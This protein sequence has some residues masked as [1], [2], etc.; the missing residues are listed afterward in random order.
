MRDLTVAEGRRFVER[1][2]QVMNRIAASRLVTVAAVNG[3][4]LGGGADRG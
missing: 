1:G 3:P 4:A 2:H